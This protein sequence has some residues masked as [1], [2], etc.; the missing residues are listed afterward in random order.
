MEANLT[1]SARTKDSTRVLEY[2]FG[3]YCTVAVPIAASDVYGEIVESGVF[4]S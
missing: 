1:N 4:C 3:N 2:R